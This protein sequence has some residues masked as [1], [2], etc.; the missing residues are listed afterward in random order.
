M[1]LELL[2]RPRRVWALIAAGCVGLLAFGWYLQ[3]VVG[4]VP[5]PMRSVQRYVM[6]LE[7]DLRRRA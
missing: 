4:L 7:R 1:G 6:A 3:Q 5:C 2:D